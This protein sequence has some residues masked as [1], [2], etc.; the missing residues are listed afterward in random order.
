M[1]MFTTSTK[2]I[3]RQLDLPVAVVNEPAR[4]LG[5]ASYRADLRSWRIPAAFEAEFIAL[6]QAA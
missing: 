4:D 3:A 1:G 5:I 2:R 6:L